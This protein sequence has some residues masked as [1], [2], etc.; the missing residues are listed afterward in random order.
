MNNL[1]NTLRWNVFDLTMASIALFLTC[2]EITMYLHRDLTPALYL[3][4]CA[5]K[6]LIW[7]ASFIYNIYKFGVAW[8]QGGYNRWYLLVALVVGLLV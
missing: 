1:T 4:S 6:I 5:T 8:G 7:S 2:L 3:I